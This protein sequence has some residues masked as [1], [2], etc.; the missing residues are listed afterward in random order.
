MAHCIFSIP[1]SQS[2]DLMVLNV[3]NAIQ[4]I[5]HA[6][7][8]GDTTIGSFSLPS[9]LGNIKGTYK[10]NGTVAE[11]SIEQKPML[12]PCSMIEAK[13]THYLNSTN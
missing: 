8:V 7:F 3:K 1:F 5:E 6:S 13:L 4:K 11:F 10:I 9:P 2:V 12:V